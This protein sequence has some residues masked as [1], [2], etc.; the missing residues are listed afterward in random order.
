MPPPACAPPVPHLC[1]PPTRAP[2]LPRPCTTHASLR[3]TC[4]RTG[5]GIGSGS[6]IGIGV[7]IGIGMY[8][9]SIPVAHIFVPVG[10]YCA[11]GAAVSA[12]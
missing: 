2:P 9:K 7:G 10:Y 11:H 5:D 6:G 8:M 1:P 3:P 4:H 12:C